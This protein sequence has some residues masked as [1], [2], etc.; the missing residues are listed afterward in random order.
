MLWGT[1]P[2]QSLPHLEP[3]TTSN[4]LTGVF[5]EQPTQLEDA[6]AQVVT[7][8]SRRSTPSNTS[9]NARQRTS[10]PIWS[11]DNGLTAAH[12]LG[13]KPSARGVQVISGSRIRRVATYRCVCI[14]G[15]RGAS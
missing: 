14:Q 3:T 9:K 2:Q 1:S 15:C 6:N 11:T 5:V 8:A 10:V 13:R 4:V 7:S 12:Y